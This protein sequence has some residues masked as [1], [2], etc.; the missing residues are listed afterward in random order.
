MLKYSEEV[1]SPNGFTGSTAEKE[2]TFVLRKLK[3]DAHIIPKDYVVLLAL[4][5]QC[6]G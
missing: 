1:T 4:E 3:N 5:E 6:R 2:F